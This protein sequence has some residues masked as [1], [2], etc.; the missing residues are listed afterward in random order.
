MTAATTATPTC[1]PNVT[2]MLDV[3]LVLLIVFMS[4]TIQVHRTLDVQLPEPCVG[5]CNG[6]GQIIL[7]VRPGPTYR[8]NTVDVAGRDLAAELRA[9][10]G[11]RPEKVIQIAGYPGVRYDDIVGAMDVAKS[12]GVRV[13]GLA[14]R[15]S[16]LRK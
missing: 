9:V 7:E 15:E 12:A 11:P 3:L 4:V 10:F 8:I 1:E 16:Y 13:V 5:A 2:P 6:T 14:P